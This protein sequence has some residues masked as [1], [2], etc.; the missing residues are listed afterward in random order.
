MDTKLAENEWQRKP[1]ETRAR[2]GVRDSK[3]PFRA[4]MVFTF[5]LLIAPQTLFPALAPMRVA[6]IAAL[7]AVL[8]YSL[9]RFIRRR[10]LVE[11]SR[12]TF[13][14]ICLLG[15]TVVTIPLSYWPGGSVSYLL[16]I[17]AKTLI[18]FWLLSHVVN[19]MP[20]LRFVAWGL[21]L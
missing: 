19:T 1:A 15:W 3:T 9:D 12:E 13:L 14:V 16:N 10:S 5:I 11:F 8:S 20:R 21:S 4:L 7:I 17:Y 2:A 6:M 18:I